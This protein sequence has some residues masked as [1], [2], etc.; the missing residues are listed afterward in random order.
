MTAADILDRLDTPILA[1]LIYRY[2][3]TGPLGGASARLAR[4][5]RNHAQGLPILSFA[6]VLD[7]YLTQTFGLAETNDPAIAAENAKTLKAARAS[8]WKA[9]NGIGDP[10]HVEGLI[11]Y[12][13]AKEL[14]EC[15]AET[16]A[17]RKGV[18]VE[19]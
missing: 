6:E 18:D 16:I 5:I 3:Y 1:R 4:I 8:F 19:S 11:R 2:F 15:I 10:E 12:A 13:H 14:S 17:R 9:L 7:E